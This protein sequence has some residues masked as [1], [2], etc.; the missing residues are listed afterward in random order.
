MNKSSPVYYSGMLYGY[1]GGYFEPIDSVK[2]DVARILM[3]VW[4]TYY[5]HYP[6]KINL[7]D[8]IQSYDL[9]MTWHIQDKPDALEGIRNNYSQTSKQKN[10][11]PF[12]DRPEYAWKIFGEKVSSTVLNNAME[13]Y[14]AEGLEPK[15]AVSLAISGSATKKRLFCR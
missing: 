4:T 2:G 7:L 15:T 14:P 8:V 12:V 9:L 10:R 1:K 5:D 11:N 13:T 3:Y 6:N